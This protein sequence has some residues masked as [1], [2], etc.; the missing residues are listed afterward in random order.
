MPALDEVRHYYDRNTSSFLRT[1]Q[2]GQAIHRA[3]WG[4]GVTTRDEAFAYLDGLLAGL[5][6]QRPA[7]RV[8]DLGCGVGASLRRLAKRSDLH[9]VGVTLSPVQAQFAQAEFTRAGLGE[10]LRCV[11]GSFTALPDELG[12]FDAA[13]SIEAFIHSPSA[14]AYLAQAAKHLKPGGVLAL[15]DDFPTDAPETARSRRWLHEVRTGWLANT[16][17]SPPQLAT[18]AARHGLTLR[19]DEDLTPYLELRRPRDLL[20]SAVMSVGRYLPVRSPLWRSW[21]GG[22][23]LQLALQAGVLAYRFLVFE[24]TAP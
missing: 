14:D 9:G 12:L 11:E 17:E 20:L 19:R 22:N 24:K 1:G 5:V 6:A 18:L 3:V 2:G 4:P 16:L 10:R 8:L 23:A 15:I 13:F 21:V 7:P